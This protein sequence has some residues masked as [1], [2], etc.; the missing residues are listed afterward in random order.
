MQNRSN[1]IPILI[2][3]IITIISVSFFTYIFKN[4]YNQSQY[5][6]NQPKVLGT[7]DSIV[8]SAVLPYYISLTVKPEGR[9]ATNN[10]EIEINVKIVN[11]NNFNAIIDETLTTNFSGF[12]DLPSVNPDTFTAGNYDIYIKGSSHLTSKFTNKTI[13]PIAISDHDLTSK[14]LRAGDAHP[15]ADD[16]INSLDISYIINNFGTND[17]RA[18][19]DKNGIVNESDIELLLNNL[20]QKGDK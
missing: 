15:I 12:V 2:A 20:Y 14:V 9:D 17:I 19:L 13:G 16:Y 5:L 8:V 4:A 11:H 6:K 7:E 10:N 1:K 18:D 3:F